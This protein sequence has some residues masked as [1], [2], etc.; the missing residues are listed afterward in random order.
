MVA[1][2]GWTVPGMLLIPASWSPTLNG[3]ETGLIR[4]E[5]LLLMLAALAKLLS[6]M[7]PPQM[8]AGVYLLARPFAWLG[9]DC[10][11]LAVRLA[12]TLEQMENMPRITR[13]PGTLALPARQGEGTG[14]M[15]L[16]VPHVAKQDI[17]LLSGAVLVLGL[18]LFG[19]PA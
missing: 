9:L 12:L 4:I 10:R 15:C 6:M 19:V 1:L 17:A 16:H 13:W 2:Y 11:A 3:L 18:A 5:R 8:A 14:E 7:K